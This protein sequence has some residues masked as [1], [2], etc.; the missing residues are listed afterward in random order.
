MSSPRTS[1]HAAHTRRRVEKGPSHRIADPPA[2][3]L[4]SLIAE[5]ST[6]L[7]DL[8]STDVDRA[9][10]DAQRSVCDRLGLEASM[11]GQFQVSAPGLVSLTH[12]HAPHGRLLPPDPLDAPRCFPWA[13][14]RVMAGETTAIPSPAALPPEAARDQESWREL[15][16]KAAVVLPLSAWG[17]PLIGALAFDTT[18]EERAWPEALVNQLRL[19]A[20][21]IADA[22]VRK[23]AE[24]AL[25][26]SEARLASAIDIAGLGFYEGGEGGRV[27]YL[28]WR[29]RALLGIPQGE[30][31]RMR[32][33]WVERLHPDDRAW[34]L[35]MSRKI[36]SGGQNW[37]VRQYRYRHPERG[38]VWIHHATRVSARDAAGNATHLIGVVQ[39][40]TDRKRTET[41]I[42]DLAGRYDTIT[43]TTTDG[44]CE[45]DGK[46]RILAANDE[47]CR[48]YAYGR[49]ELLTKS[50]FDLEA[51]QSPLEIRQN[52][53]AIQQRESS[54]FETRH[55]CKDGRVLDIE[56]STTYR[57]SSDTFLTFLR[58]VT[59]RRRSE[60]QLQEVLGFNR[61]ILA[62]LVDNMVIL[63]R[64]GTILAANDAW[65]T[66]AL[67]NGGPGVLAR[68][69]VGTN[70]LEVCR[71]AGA[72]EALDGIEAVLKGSSAL[73]RSEYACHSPMASRWY[74][75]E[76]MPLRRAEGGVVVVHR[77]ITAR[78]KAEEELQ[79]LRMHSWH[80][81]RVAQTGAIAASL[82]HE[83]NQ[84]L[85]AILSNAQAGV[86]LMAAP[87]PDLEEIRAILT[88][89]VYDDKRAA[90][91]IA[92]LRAMLR[93]KETYRERLDLART[94]REV[95]AL[96]HSE[97]IAHGVEV[98]LRAESDIPVSADSAQVQQ[99]VLNLVMNAIEA[100]EG[101]PAGHRRLEL[102]LAP[103][104][105][106]EALLAVRDSGTGIPE[107][108]QTR[109]FDAF[110]TTKPHGMGIGLPICRSIIESHGGHLWFANN[111]DQGV[112]FFVSLPLNVARECVGAGGGRLE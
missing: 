84:P 105:A 78:K 14:Q 11:L 33:Y 19:V 8:P 5:L 112:T 56:V 16:V 32:E 1:A 7:L 3:E 42:G 109:L 13:L 110:W 101:Q 92:G 36:L 81:H 53:I 35:E 88:D 50:L 60:A 34:V 68:A 80:A 31:H 9:I 90:A 98:E 55:R 83:L 47:A 43:S 15:G 73:Y 93:R 2:I 27:T 12:V 46:G 100:M 52:I 41:A 21:I 37:A 61:N 22:L 58:D 45:I 57:R 38:L 72:L 77:D 51:K 65:E 40:I 17:H 10:R 48:M 87:G 62:S 103:T 26:E 89:I 104:P 75:I 91:V 108:Q 94:I 63:D 6:K 44:F 24:T 99:V 30:D 29:T 4:E 39:D 82:A 70:Y 95:L 111:E 97:L 74:Q 67:E 59:A 102:S 107:D 96:A 86:R 79:G 20:R 25:T 28:D 85:A 64:Q 18:R 66:F 23:S 76:V 106:G 54:R 69:G 71:R 49:D